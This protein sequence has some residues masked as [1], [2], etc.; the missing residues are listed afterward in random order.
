MGNMC[1]IIF[2]GK[3]GRLYTF[4]L[5]GWEMCSA[6]EHPCDRLKLEVGFLLLKGERTEGMW[7]VLAVFATQMYHIIV[8]Q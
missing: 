2:L 1:L 3:T 8:I 4:L 6:A 7:S 5:R